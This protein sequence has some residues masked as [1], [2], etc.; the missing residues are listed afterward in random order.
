MTVEGPLA[1]K[2]T[3]GLIASYL[4]HVFENICCYF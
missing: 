1:S 3:A 2:K 4:L